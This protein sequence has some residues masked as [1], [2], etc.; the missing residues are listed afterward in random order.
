MSTLVGVR[1]GGIAL[2][3][4]LATLATP[5]LARANEAVTDSAAYKRGRLLYIQC[6][7]CHDLKAGGQRKVGP[8]LEE[9]VGRSVAAV[10]DFGYSEAL[11]SS[12]LVWDVA[13]LDRWLQRPSE[14]VPGNTM[15]FA[16][17]ASE[18]DRAALITYISVDSAQ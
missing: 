15:A 2:W 18:A 4:A 9:I 10:K 16:G 3:L 8:H 5:T 14:L 12:G 1:L 17:I 13:T 11:E 7:A 6:R